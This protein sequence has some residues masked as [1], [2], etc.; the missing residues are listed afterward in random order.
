VNLYRLPWELPATY[1]ADA[2][3]EVTLPVKRDKETFI[4]TVYKKTPLGTYYYVE[5]WDGKSKTIVPEFATTFFVD[6]EYKIDDWG[7]L[8][9]RICAGQTGT[10]QILKNY[11]KTLNP[12]K[13]ADRYRAEQTI[14]SLLYYFMPQELKAKWNNYI[15]NIK[16]DFANKKIYV[17][18]RVGQD[19]VSL[20]IALGLVI[21]G[22]VIGYIAGRSAGDAEK[23]KAVADIWKDA[24]KIIQ[25]IN[26]LEKQGLLTPEEAKTY[27]N[28][29][30]EL[31]G[32]SQKNVQPD[33]TTNLVNTVVAILPLIIIIMLVK[34]LMG[35]V[36]R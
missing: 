29:I 3:G 6:V 17:T 25:L 15:V 21:L 36:K 12:N 19:P 32:E 23:A 31:L 4:L 8:I 10:A 16:V 5:N 30:L 11:F 1:I 28:K 20:A 18:F 14:L 34:S 26:D 9:D 22:A 7:K 13:E 33:G 35:V 2:N 27:I 24:D